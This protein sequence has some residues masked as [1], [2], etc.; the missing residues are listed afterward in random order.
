MSMLAERFVLGANLLV[1]ETI[2]SHRNKF[3]MVVNIKS[4]GESKFN[5]NSVLTLPT[6]KP[7]QNTAIDVEHIAFL[8]NWIDCML[9]FSTVL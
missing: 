1:V 5:Y 8:K 9:E 2:H 7:I 4:K 6:S 3:V